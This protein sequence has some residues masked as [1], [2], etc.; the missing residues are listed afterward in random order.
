MNACSNNRAVTIQ[1]IIHVMSIGPNR[2]VIT[3]INEV[4]FFIL[5]LFV[6]L[7]ASLSGGPRGVYPPT[8][9]A[10]FPPPILTPLP[11]PFSATPSPHLRNF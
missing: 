3:S 8:A 6:D 11:P 1:L 2:Y 10:L 4:V 7:F 9:M 5:R